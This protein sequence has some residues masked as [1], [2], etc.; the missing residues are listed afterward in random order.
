MLASVEFPDDKFDTV[1][2]GTDTLMEHFSRNVFSP[3]Y[4]A[5]RTWA[6][7]AV[8]LAAGLLFASLPAVNLVNLNV[9]RILVKDGRTRNVPIVVL[10][11]RDEPDFE[12]LARDVGAAS[13]FVKPLP[14]S[15]LD[16]LIGRYFG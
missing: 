16:L 2:G 12:A 15:V 6:L 8:L 1:A 13:Y 3:D 7:S 14:K 11:S 9:S 5:T 4:G 10:S